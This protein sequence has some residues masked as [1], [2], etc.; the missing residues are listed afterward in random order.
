MKKVC[1]IG[2]FAEKS[3]SLDGQTVKTRTLYSELKHILE[4]NQVSKV[5]TYRWR[6]NPIKLIYKCW[7]AL[8]EHSNVIIM[9]AQNGIR[10][11]VPLLVLLNYIFNRQLIYV[12]IGGWLPERLEKQ[13]SIF[14]F[15][16]KLDSIHV[17]TYLMKKKLENLGM[18][19]IYYL[20]NFK[21]INTLDE[22][23]LT[24]TFEEP[25]KLCTFS[26]VMKEKGIEDA[27]I[28]VTEI[29]NTMGRELFQLDI[30]G[31]V[32]EN[33]NSEF[34]SVISGVNSFVKYKGKVDSNKS[35]EV[36]KDY[37]AL[38]FPT[39]YEGEGFA[40]TL[41]DALAAGIPVIASD[42]KYNSEIITND[43]EGYI[44][45]AKDIEMLKKSILDMCYNTNKVIEFKKNCLEKSK[46][47]NSDNIMKKFMVHLK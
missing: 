42:W 13:K 12:V 4:E 26:R 41:L 43:Y 16:K 39:Y 5:D 1:I 27:I 24:Y 47:Y 29:N 15:A 8:K 11:F 40:G 10:V 45:K 30:Y 23:K 33:Y 37:F 9:P 19:N 21:R 25:Y 44:F 46:I 32:D 20:P 7:N 28:A 6:N 2:H 14:K 22:K 3:D 35:V 31:Q 34:Q 36:L 17:E 18:N 38:L